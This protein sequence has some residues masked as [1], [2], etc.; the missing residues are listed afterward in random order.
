MTTKIIEE[1]VSISTLE[2][3]VTTKLSIDRRQMCIC[4]SRIIIMGCQIGDN[5]NQLPKN[6]TAAK[7]LENERLKDIVYYEFLS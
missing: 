1:L 5:Q 2:G 4:F 6:K 7:S 3:K